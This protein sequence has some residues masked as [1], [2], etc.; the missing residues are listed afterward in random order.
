MMVRCFCNRLVSTFRL[1]IVDH[2]DRPDNVSFLDSR[3]EVRDEGSHSCLQSLRSVAITTL[4]RNPVKGLK[5]PGG[6][7][8][9][10][11]GRQVSHGQS[12]LNI[13]LL[14]ASNS[15]KSITKMKF[16]IIRI[17]LVSRVILRSST[18]SHPTLQRSGSHH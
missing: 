1:M 13:V 18:M 16:Y 5:E 14:G 9:A 2:D 12:F 17:R 3:F 11:P 7:R 8:H 10:D 4:A 6:E 15:K